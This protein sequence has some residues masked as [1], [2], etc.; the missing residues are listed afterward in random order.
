MPDSLKIHLAQCNPVVGDLQGN[1]GRAREARAA[2]SSAD[3]IVF[4]ELFITG[5]P[6]EDLV[7]KPFFNEKAREVAE[8]LA[9]ETADGGPAVIIGSP[10][11]EDGLVYNATLVM[12]EG[13]IIAACLKHDLPNYGVFD[14]KRVFAAGPLPGPVNI[15]G[16]RMGVMTCEDM[17]SADVAECLEESGAEILVVPNGSPFE[18]GKGDE[19]MQHAVSRVTETGLPLIYVNQI[20]GQDELVFDGG[21][22]VL[23]ADRTL[24]VQM[25][26]FREAHD[27]THW[28]RSDDD[29]WVCAD[30]EQTAPLPELEQIYQALVLGLRDYV[31]KNGFP[32]VLLGLSGGVDSAISAAVAVDALGADK[33][34]C[35][36]MP[37]RY[38]DRKS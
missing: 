25:P 19:R 16:V 30:G 22:F 1:L 36:M 14:E 21:S 15:R 26:A 31:T 34:H 33:V 32:G 37:Y 5:Y 17:W 3:I 35:D 9:K 27:L 6:P 10:W 24:P 29:V 18:F 2:A 8:E 4:P 12:D 7:L 13:R 28:S 38:T 11:V 23:N 20:A